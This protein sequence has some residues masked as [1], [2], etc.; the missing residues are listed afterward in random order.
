MVE[1]LDLGDPFP[2]EQ[3]IKI[4][5]KRYVLRSATAEVARKYRNTTLRAG[6]MVDGKVVGMDGLADAEPEAVGACLLSGDN[7][8][9]L[10]VGTPAILAWDCS[11]QTKLFDL[12]K[13]MS[14]TLVSGVSEADA[15]NSPGGGPDGSSSPTASSST[16]G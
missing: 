8:G 3:P 10:P 5:G 12:L 9:L 7:G 15:K 13:K 14:P 16:P 1:E 2:K 11:I 6:R 4:G